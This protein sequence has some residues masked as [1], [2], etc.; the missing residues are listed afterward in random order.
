MASVLKQV[1]YYAI[2]PIVNSLD[3]KQKVLSAG[4]ND[5]I[6]A[7]T[8][9]SI[10]I[11]K[12]NIHNPTS[13]EATI[14]FKDIITKANGTTDVITVGGKWKVGPGQ[15]LEITMDDVPHAFTKL[16]I[17]TDVANLEVYGTVE[18]Y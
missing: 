5:I 8:G 14:Y 2:H 13:S 3:L 16:I 17:N 18:V 6:T 10:K 7:P 1:I 9:H 11:K 4:D 12:L 15:T